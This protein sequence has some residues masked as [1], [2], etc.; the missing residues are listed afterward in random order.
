MTLA[1]DQIT[2]AVTVYN[3]RHFLRQCIA[4]ALEQT[5]PVRVIVV[6]DC[7]PD[8]GMRDYVQEQFGTRVEYFR[9]PK[10]RGLF[11]N[12]NACMDL[13]GTPWLS[14]LHDDDF[15]APQFVEAMLAL[16]AR[17]PDCALYFGMTTIVDESGAPMP[18]GPLPKFG[19]PWG[20]VRLEDTLEITPFP[21]PGQLFLVA[22]ARAA[23]G[24][25]E[26]SGYCG[27]WEMWCH[28]IERRGGAQTAINV[29]FNRQHGG[30]ERDSN[31]VWRAGRAFPLTYVQRK[32][33]LAMLRRRGAAPVFDRADFQ[34]R[35][36]V[37]ARYL[38][39]HGATL[40]RRVLRYHLGLLRLSPPMNWK[41]AVFRRLALLGGLRFVQLASLLWNRLR[42]GS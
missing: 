13:A 14:I 6:E 7:G 32:R 27:D 37:P 25:R 10:R 3:R 34:S 42:P 4:S 18:W 24:F 41:Y 35:G 28:L 16:H 30:V 23:G 15:L 8:P 9:N 29:A 21:F 26:T 33:I 2:I 20:R 31:A 1:A 39:R 12:W 17:A 40:P 36:Q 22:E 38:L 11:G 19:E 5:V